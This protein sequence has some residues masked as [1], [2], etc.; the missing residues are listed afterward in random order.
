MEQF[1]LS[2]GGIGKSQHLKLK[3]VKEWL[4]FWQ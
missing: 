2:I 1:Y 4:L 3:I